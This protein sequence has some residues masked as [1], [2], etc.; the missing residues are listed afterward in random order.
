M[1]LFKVKVDYLTI[2]IVMSLAHLQ[3]KREVS[4]SE[5]SDALGMSRQNGIKYKD[6]PL[7]DEEIRTL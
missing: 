2:S 1:N 6:R 5:V 3:L 4:R 7:T